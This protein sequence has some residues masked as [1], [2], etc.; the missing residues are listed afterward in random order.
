MAKWTDQQMEIAIGYM[1]RTGVMLA[2][3]V[4]LA[5]GIMYLA[6]LH[7]ARPDYSHFHGV[8]T[9]FRTPQDILGGFH[10][11]DSK[12]IIQLGLLILVATPVFRV[13]MAAVGFLFEKDWMYVAVSLLVLVILLYSLFDHH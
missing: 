10:W 3:A 4:V 8:A 12:S 5:G 6:Q 13:V 11:N 2:A 9:A 1:L 7:G